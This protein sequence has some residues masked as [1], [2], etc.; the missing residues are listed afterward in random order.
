MGRRKKRVKRKKENV[1]KAKRGDVW[2]A[3]SHPI[4]IVILEAP[5]PYGSRQGGHFLNSC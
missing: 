2:L 1:R 4:Y 5:A 3:P